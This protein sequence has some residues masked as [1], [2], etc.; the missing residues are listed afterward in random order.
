MVWFADWLKL[1]KVKRMLR[2]YSPDSQKRIIERG[3]DP[4]PLPPIPVRHE[5]SPEAGPS[6]KP[7]RSR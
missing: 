5:R 4:R 1:R 6:A 3:M 2:Q 7:E